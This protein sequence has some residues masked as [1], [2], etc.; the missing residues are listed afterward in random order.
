MRWLGGIKNKGQVKITKKYKPAYNLQRLFTTEKIYF[1]RIS[2]KKQAELKIRVV[3]SE[4]RK[5]HS[6]SFLYLHKFSYPNGN[7]PS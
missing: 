6:G 3:E 5:Y 2:E 4:K 1:C 7:G